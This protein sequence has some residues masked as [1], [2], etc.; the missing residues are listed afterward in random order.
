MSTTR[1]LN[2]IEIRLRES[3]YSTADLRRWV[4]RLYQ[5]ED[6]SLHVQDWFRV[7][8]NL[9]AVMDTLARV[10]PSENIHLEALQTFED[11][12]LDVDKVKALRGRVSDCPPVLID[13]VA[14]VVDG[15]HR[16]AAARL[17]GL[18]TI[19]AVRVKIPP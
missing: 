8:R 18:V 14:R 5:M 7:R 16:V 2:S 9:L 6:Q 1:L 4:R 13:D 19:Q 3:L 10:A 15:N 17:D 11:H 12:K